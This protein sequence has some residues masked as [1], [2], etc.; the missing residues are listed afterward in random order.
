L[1]DEAVF[2]RFEGTLDGKLSVLIGDH[3]SAV[4]QLRFVFTEKAEPQRFAALTDRLALSPVRLESDALYLEF[5]DIGLQGLELRLGR[6]QI[7]WGTADRFH[8]VSNLN[9]LDVEDPLKFGEVIANE[10]ISLRYRPDFAVGCEGEDPIFTELGFEVVVVPY[11]KPAQLPQSAGL[12]FSDQAE[13]ERRVDTPLVRG[14]IEQQRALIRA[15][16]TFGYNPLVETPEFKGDNVMLGAR[17]SWRLLSIDMGFSYFYGFDDFPRAEKIVSRVEL[18]DLHADN[19]ITLT[20]PRVHVAGFDMA[21]SLPFLDGLGLWGEL[22]FTVHDDLYRIIAT[23][24]VI[25]VNEIEVEQP[26][27][28]FVKAVVGMDY[29]PLP[30]WYLNIQYLYGFLDEFGAS[31]LDHY[32]VGGMDFKLAREMLL[33]R[34]FSIWNL[35]DGSFVLF[36]QIMVRPW[37]GAELSVGAFL[38]SSLFPRNPGLNFPNPADKFSS[39]AAGHPNVFLKARVSF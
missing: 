34:L 1:D 14:L 29:T 33:I 8:A 9:P 23:G 21:T 25:G 13:L 38:F 36:P 24:P 12:A 4:A 16:W 2:E 26:G 37:S 6:Q 15:G 17:M 3:V 39:P 7:I 11:F 5:V 10:M 31:K 35:N 19:D 30:W 32:I 22:A 27:G 20:Y 28:F 18:G